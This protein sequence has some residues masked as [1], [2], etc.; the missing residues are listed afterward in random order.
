MSLLRTRFRHLLGGLV[1][2]AIPCILLLSVALRVVLSR[3]VARLPAPVQA[4]AARAEQAP[5][6][7]MVASSEQ[8]ASLLDTPPPTALSPPLVSS[9][10]I[11]TTHHTAYSDTGANANANERS[12]AAFASLA[13]VPVPV[14][15]VEQLW[16]GDYR[17]GAQLLQPQL[18]AGCTSARSGRALVSMV[19]LSCQQGN[20]HVKTP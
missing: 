3:Y 11:A 5:L 9:S 1:L 18:Q 19:L 8:A 7:P 20:D 13:R 16:A 17:H 6:L 14:P 15:D 10:S 2:G 12:G 4:L